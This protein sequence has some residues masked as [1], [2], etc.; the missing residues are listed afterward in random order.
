MRMR[1]R[2]LGRDWL[3]FLG[4]AALIVSLVWTQA[5]IRGLGNQLE[6]ARADNAALAAQV[7]AL[8]GKPVVGPPVP[9]LDKFTAAQTAA[10]RV[11]VAD[12][13]ASTPA[14]LTQSEISQIA[15]T[16]AALVPK[17]RD[18]K[19]PTAAQLQPI[20]T[21]TLA[22]YCAGDKCVGK[23]GKDG[24]DGADGKDAPAVTDEQLLAAA[25]QTLTAYCAQE[26]RPCDGTDGKDGVDGKDGRGITKTEC[27]QD[28][29]WLFSYTDGT[30]QTVD[31]PCRVIPPIGPGN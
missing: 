17:P 25:Q 12:Q 19:T 2:W 16:S 21:A 26:S 10:I 7:R 6:Q 30:T 20:V 11:I 29:T 3:Y 13:I 15:R 27:Q 4:L 24:R 14:K 1:A 18:G 31:G 23:A 5:S 22:A 8:G 28:G 9:P